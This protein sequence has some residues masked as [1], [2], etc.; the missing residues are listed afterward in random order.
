MGI[1]Y[2]AQ[3]GQHDGRVAGLAGFLAQKQRLIIVYCGSVIVAAIL[4]LQLMSQEMRW[5]YLAL[6]AVAAV[7]LV[8][9]AKLLAH[10]V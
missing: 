6:T 2:V 3:A 10:S 9:L 4:A 8:A 7:C 5:K 1:A